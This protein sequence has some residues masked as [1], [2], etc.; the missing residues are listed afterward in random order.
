MT[1]LEA[2][3]TTTSAAVQFPTLLLTGMTWVPALA[4]LGTLFFPTR[5]AAERQRIRSFALASTVLVAALGVL[6]WYGFSAQS[7]TYAYEE[8]RPWLPS[9]GASYHLGVDGISM[10]L[11]LLSSVLFAF[12]VLASNRI[13][14]QVKEYFVLLLLL[15]TGVNGV[16]SSLDYL[17]FFFFWQLQAVPMFLLIARFGGPRRMAAAWRLLALDLAAGGILLLAILILYFKSPTHTFDIA[18]L[19]DLNLPTAMATLVTWLFLIA[20]AVKLPVPPFH[21]GFIDAQAEAPAPV[22]MILTGVVVKMGGYGIVRVVVGEFQ[23]ALHA[24][25]GA[26]AVIAVVTVLW[27]ALAALAQDDLRRLIGYVVMSHMGL[28]LLAG[29]SAVPVALNGSVLM[30]VADGLTA[31]L[32]MVL[33]TAIVDRAN[34]TSM[35]AM[36]GLAGRMGRGAILWITAA[37]AALGLPGLAGFTGQ[38]LIALGAYPALRVAT[39]IAFLGTIGIAAGMIWSVQRIFF[40]PL[41]ENY[42]RVRDLGTLELGNAVGLLSPIVLLGVLPAILMDNI[43]FSTLTLLS[44]SGG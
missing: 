43:N 41:P 20:F 24:I 13:R 35:R 39:P 7:G 9:I 31:A 29:A 8:A 4:A 5:T 25:V 36:G 22:A 33:A 34:T 27:S 19:H 2:I 1:V 6:M 30:M 14:D 11:L 12:A 37:F 42:E 10:S 15:E 16:F 21:T 17:L 32:L 40:G 38:L 44:R 3:P 26:V 23:V 18:T 28:V